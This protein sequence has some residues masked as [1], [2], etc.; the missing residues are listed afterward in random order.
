MRH[1]VNNVI[2]RVIYH[3]V[4]AVV[5]VSEGVGREVRERFAVS[6]ARVHAIPNPAIPDAI[7]SSGV[8]E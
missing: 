1:A 7:A 5:A 8:S 3:H 6:A 4:D 2:A